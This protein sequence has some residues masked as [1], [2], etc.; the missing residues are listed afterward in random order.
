[1][2]STTPALFGTWRM[3][4]RV[5]KTLDGKPLPPPA[6][7]S[8]WYAINMGLITF[9]EGGRIMTVLCDGRIGLPAEHQRQYSSDVGS[10]AFDGETLTINVENSAQGH[11]GVRQTRKVRFD[12]AILVLMPPPVEVDGE[13]VQREIH[14][15][16]IG[17]AAA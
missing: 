15:E 9:T 16:R 17:I 14:W 12:D 4:R 1:M 2:N 10:Y 13:T 11:S 8:G 5:T 3:V 7:P 6:E